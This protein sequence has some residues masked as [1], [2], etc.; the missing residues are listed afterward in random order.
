MGHK[1]S[2]ILLIGVFL[3]GLPFTAYS[4]QEKNPHQRVLHSIIAQAAN[5]HRVEIALVKAMIMA[6]SRYDVDAV[7]DRGA[8]GLM[9]LMPTTA[10][11]LGVEDCF[12]PEQNVDAGV[13][14]FKSLK[15]Q[16]D[17][18]VILALA[19]YYA[20]P[21]KVKKCGGIS[22]ATSTWQYIMRVLGFYRIYKKGGTPET[23]L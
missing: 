20:G 1:V 10:K 8:R 2:G 19:A 9:Q 18:N 3:V 12:D 21:A 22:D 14:Y 6:E 7:S 23:S 4:F 16:F 13:R 5:R 17:G 11:S 15:I